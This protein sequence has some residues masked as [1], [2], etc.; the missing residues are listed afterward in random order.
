MDNEAA[1]WEEEEAYHGKRLKLSETELPAS[2]TRDNAAALLFAAVPPV[3]PHNGIAS[4]GV[5]NLPAD[6]VHLI[7][8]YLCCRG[9]SISGTST[10]TSGSSSSSSSSS[11]S[12]TSLTWWL[13][14]IERELCLVSR[15]FRSCVWEHVNRKTTMLSLLP[16]K[17][18][19]ALA[20][21]FRRLKDIVIC[22]QCLI[23]IYLYAVCSS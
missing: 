8:G 7:L 22:K 10:S 21:R 16:N 23:T 14:S 11:S 3:P 1:S 13:N 2:R 19:C 15:L 12:N 4:G 5:R 17:R 18:V 6:V 9:E 20:T